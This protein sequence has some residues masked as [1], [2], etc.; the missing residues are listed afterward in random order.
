MQFLD[1]YSKNEPFN[2][3]DV[4]ATFYVGL[5]TTKPPVQ[6]PRTTEDCLFLDVIVPKK[7]FDSSTHHQINA[8]GGSPVLVWIYGGGFSYG[9][10]PSFGNPAGL[11]KA[12]NLTDPDGVIVVLF[13]YRGHH[14]L[15][16][17][18]TH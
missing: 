5:N 17:I 14:G 9:D 18:T 10:K 3:T 1:A 11:I 4:N 16:G 12:S 13:N 7:V 2:F 6:D 15:T 8:M